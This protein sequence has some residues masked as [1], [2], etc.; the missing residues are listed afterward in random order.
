MLAYKTKADMHA[1]Y[2]QSLPSLVTFP[3]LWG[4]K[5]VNEIDSK[6]LYRSMELTKNSIEASHNII[7]YKGIDVSYEDYA[8]CASMAL[9]RSLP[10][11]S[12]ERI[13]DSRYLICLLA[14][15][16]NHSNN[17]NVDWKIEKIKFQNREEENIIVYTTKD[18]EQLSQLYFNY[19]CRSNFH[20]CNKY[21][22]V[23]EKVMKV[24][25]FLQD[26]QFIRSYLA[27][28]SIISKLLSIYKLSFEHY[29]MQL[30]PN[31]PNDY[32]TFC[33]IL[34]ISNQK[35]L[36]KGIKAIEDT[37][38]SKPLPKME[39]IEALK[40]G[41]HELESYR[42]ML[43]RD[44]ESLLDKINPVANKESF[45]RHNVYKLMI[46]EKITLDINIKDLKN[47]MIKATELMA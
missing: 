27:N 14:D 46:N 29:I 36:M 39:E 28:Q 41:L 26:S 18:I 23:T 4:S 37:D 31:N 47:S 20:F 13:K 40:K 35:L 5:E 12:D 21:G 2:I 17:S 6:N 7:T 22:F 44:Y 33:R 30:N 42:I 38:Y 43:N 25:I 24:D 8:W 11:N 32:K 1:A 45:D 19:N 34:N 10:F 9:S 3:P 15:Y 16:I